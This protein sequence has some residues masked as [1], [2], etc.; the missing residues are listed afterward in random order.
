MTDPR[1]ISTSND[2]TTVA[3][4][5]AGL[6]PRIAAIAG[7]T[8]GPAQL[9][10][11]LMRELAETVG[12]PYTRVHIRT[13]SEVL[14]DSW[15]RGGGGPDPWRG[16]AMG[17]LDD[18]L[19]TGRSRSRLY[20]SRDG[21][22]SI[23][24]VG[25]QVHDAQGAGLGAIVL[26]IPG[27]TERDVAPVTAELGRVLATAASLAAANASGASSGNGSNRFEVDAIT[28]AAGAQNRV[29][30]AFVLANALRARTGTEMVA[31]GAVEGPRVRLMAISGF[32]EVKPRSPGARRLAAAMEEASDAGT[33]QIVQP[34][35]PWEDEVVSSRG[36]LHIAWHR[37][38]GGA[39]V[40]SV[41]LRAGDAR[42]GGSD[43]IVAV[44]GIRG[45]A[46]ERLDAEQI[47][48][49]ESVVAP[50]GLLMRTLQRAD[51]GV[52]RHMIDATTRWCREL[53]GPRTLVR[54]VGVAAILVGLLG[55]LFFGRLE[56]RL[57]AQATVVPA[58]A[59]QVAAPA[60][61]ALATIHV[62][63]GDRVAAGDRLA[64]MRTGELELERARLMSSIEVRRLEARRLLVADDLS[65]S[66]L[67]ETEQRALEAE[68]A[69]V[70]Q[71]IEAATIRAPI[72]GTVIAA[73]LERDL[74]R[75]LVR[76][77]PLFTVA[78]DDGWTIEVEI[79]ERDIESVAPGM[80]GLFA[81]RSRPDVQERFV[82]DRVS[83]SA[84][85]RDGRNVFV[86]SADVVDAPAW[87]RAGMEGVVRVDAG[88]RP[89][90]WVLSRST[91][92][93]VRQAFWL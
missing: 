17:L 31:I 19:Q 64:S 38:T 30:L 34:A 76:G 73:A 10:R 51:R 93:W 28:G 66:A 75:T 26:V 23:S 80:V 2:G 53:A 41:P 61:G 77:E 11:A 13:G 29:H 49:I 52:G 32:D 86:A 90:W 6:T 70:D 54:R 72:A 71:R 3:A 22:N 84:E 88:R 78:G 46:G 24:L 92:V 40:M 85:I 42:K 60:D 44:V 81:P 63:E 16:P 8:A 7:R 58:T 1:T 59:R 18:I 57:P 37:A 39:S 62:R 67:A 14:D 15:H 33:R 56:L 65:G 83:G 25:H 82:I 9:Y 12:A 68:L 45:R 48:R 43:E 89:A 36:R 27:V 69:L 79:S 47:R 87:T 55:W 5:L 35:G 91:V 20:A 50:Y 74:G 21:G 4:R